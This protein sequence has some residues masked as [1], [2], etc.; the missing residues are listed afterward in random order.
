M[1]STRRGLSAALL[2][3]ALIAPAFLAAPVLAHDPAK[4]TMVADASPAKPTE[5]KQFGAMPHASAVDIGD[6]SVPL[7]EGLGSTHVAITTADPR[8]QAYFN[9]GMVMTWGFNHWE[10]RRA[11]RAAQKLDPGCAMCFWGEALVLGPNIN[12]PMDPAANAPALTAM[13]EA[14]ARAA[15]ASPREQALIAALSKRY[16]GDPKME[17]AA[18]DLAYADA[19]QDVAARYPDD[20]TIAVLYAEALMD[21]TP[22][23][24]WADDGKTPKGRTAE[25]VATL[26]RVLAAEPD[27]IGATHL[28]IHTVEASTDH[29]RAEPYA[30]R[31]RAVDVQAGHLIHMPSHIYF[32][33]GRYAEALEANRKAVEVDEAYLA[34]VKAEGIYPGGYYPHNIHFLLVSAQMA[35]DAKTAIAAAEKLAATVSDDVAREVALAQPTKVAPYFAHA[36]FSDPKTIHA[37]SAPPEDLP[38]VKAMWHYAQG[39]AQAAEGDADAARAEAEAIDRIGRDGDFRGL[40]EALVPAP[41]IL[42]LAGHVVRAR[43]AQADDDLTTAI[44]EFEAAHAVEKSLPYFEPP[45]WYYPVRQSLAAALLL[46]GETDRAKALFAESLAAVPNNGWACFGL[47]E[48]LTRRGETAEAMKIK[49]RLDRT[50]A[51]DPA[52]LDLKRL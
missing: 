43:A 31:L 30:D 21:L 6:Q 13:K 49:E 17:R 1:F 47:A 37:L 41:D 2:A 32:R 11:F 50:W 44:A 27:H 19:M 10:A 52:L 14:I 46:V 35:G 45:Y 12:A 28:Y 33:V 39:V 7:W 40:L 26:E 34:K 18:L 23:D 24:Y 29:R 25:L 42:K 48:T 16:S 5:L 22:W 3:S 8:A 9:Q 38:Y 20:R 15:L 36:Q 51:G 4:H